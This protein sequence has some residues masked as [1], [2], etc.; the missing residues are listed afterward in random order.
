MILLGERSFCSL[1]SCGPSALYICRT[2]SNADKYRGGTVV[3]LPA[4]Y[5]TNRSASRCA[6]VHRPEI[7]AGTNPTVVVSILLSVRGPEQ[8]VPVRVQQSCHMHSNP[9][10][11]CSNGVAKRRRGTVSPPRKGDLD[12]DSCS[13]RMKGSWLRAHCYV[14]PARHL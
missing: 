11:A 13:L 5:S 6:F 14:T 2:L 9:R 10:S 1:C 7:C 3:T 12:Q 8:F 4:C